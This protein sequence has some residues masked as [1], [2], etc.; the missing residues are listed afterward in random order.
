MKIQSKK[1]L[2]KMALKT[3]K[4]SISLLMKEVAIMKKMFH[5]NLIQLFEIIDD[6]ENGKIYLIM[7]YMDLGCIGSPS[8]R[9]YLKCDNAYLP[10]DKIW[11]YFRDCMKGL[12]YR[13]NSFL[14]TF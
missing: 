3:G 5:D 11:K 1:K 12:E 2:K 7:D 4:N 8:H 6:K 9:A 10:M 13:K 14:V